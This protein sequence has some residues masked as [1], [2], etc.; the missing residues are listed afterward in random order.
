MC[1]FVEGVEST[2]APLQ[3]TIDPDGTSVPEQVLRW[4]RTA[5]G[6]VAVEHAGTYLTFAE[7]AARAAAVRDDLVDQGVLPGDRV[8]LWLGR[9][10]DLVVATLGTLLAGATYI[11]LDVREPRSRMATIL[12][13]AGDPVVITDAAHGAEVPAGRPA[14]L[15]DAASPPPSPAPAELDPPPADRPCYITYTSGSTGTPKGVE[16][17][18]RGATNLVDWYR[19]TFAVVPGDRMPQFARP[20]FDGWSLE[21]WPCLTSGATLCIPDESVLRSAEALARWLCEERIT[22]CFVTTVLGKEL[23]AQPWATFGSSLRTL[24]IGGEK[25]RGYPPALPFRVCN[26]YGPTETAMLATWDD[27]AARAE[28]AGDPPIGVPLANVTAYVLDDRLCET[29]DGEVGELYLG[30][31]GVALGY[32]G[33][34]GLTAQRFIADP[35]I[36]G[37]SRLYRTGDL[38]RRLPDG[39]LEFVGRADGQIKLRGFRIELGE[40]EAAALALP[41][42]ADAVAVVYEPPS[43][44][45][46]LVVYIRPATGSDS[47][48]V[49]LRERLGAVLPD[50]MT[51]TVQ[52][53]DEFPLTPHGKVDRVALARRIPDVP[54]GPA[55]D[56]TPM[57]DLERLLAGLWCE[58][59]D[60]TRAGRAD[61]F[62]E[63]GGDSLTAMRVAA[64][65]RD[66]GLRIGAEDLFEYE[67]LGEL[68]AAL[69]SHGVES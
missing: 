39:A 4:A 22:T 27:L 60:I 41:E 25:L 7:L 67:F 44:A 3:S 55:A 10:A 64:K 57:T 13:D 40:V 5:P 53:V 46:R 6:R 15:V 14:I 37:P 11:G 33:R 1:L 34:P 28:R 19:R 12:T 35:F 29:P 54:A 24:L 58:V 50:Y 38:V 30:G 9:S 56:V 48:H 32:A 69:E 21:A 8:A 26:V 23:F 63:L 36:P 18:H 59:L 16:V 2:L 68:A 52:T 61:S 42:V 51:P 62:F 49:V 45:G 65:A 47:D 31:A 17:T 43:E 20:S 66:R